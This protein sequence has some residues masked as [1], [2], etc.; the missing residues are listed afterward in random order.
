LKP[1]WLPQ[2]FLVAILGQPINPTPI[3]FGMGWRIGKF[4][5]TPDKF[6]KNLNGL[7]WCGGKGFKD[8]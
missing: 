8:V 5:P 7:I 6:N 4:I 3:Y 2:S 1:F